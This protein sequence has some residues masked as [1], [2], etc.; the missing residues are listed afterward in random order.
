MAHLLDC[1]NLDENDIGELFAYLRRD[2]H[3]DDAAA[4]RPVDRCCECDGHVVLDPERADYICVACG[5]VQP[6][7]AY[8]VD[9]WEDRERI[10]CGPREGYKRIHHLHERLAQ[11]HLQ[12]STICPEHWG[13]IVDAL[14]L[15]KPRALCKEGLRKVLR[16]VKLQRYNENWLQIINRLTGYVPPRLSPAEM[17]MLDTIFNGIFKPFALFKS[18][19]RKNLL[20]YNFVL[21]RLLQLLGRTDVLCHFPQ[22]KTRAKWLE[23]DRV[24]AHIC[25]FNDWDHFPAPEIVP[26]SVPTSDATW[27][28][29]SEQSMMAAWAVCDQRERP[30]AKRTHNYASRQ[31]LRDYAR[32]TSRKD[33]LS[34]TAS[35]AQP[36]RKPLSGAAAKRQ[37]L[38]GQKARASA[39]SAWAASQSAPK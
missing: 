1:D 32:A 28:R 3:A 37:L 20:N 26:L 27:A 4:E 16:S 29:A 7:R 18:E 13:R 9:C 36:A 14:Q 34:H 24:W 15:A 6:G 5:V 31:I 11:Y 25:E 19:A 10:T 8:Y 23:L 30:A 12:E 21:M 38:R 39:R 35:T 2:A 33:A 22:L 17:R